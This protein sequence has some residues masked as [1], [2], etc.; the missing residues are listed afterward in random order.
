MK[1]ADESD[2]LQKLGVL[3][4]ALQDDIKKILEIVTSQQDSINKISK[5]SERVENLEY[6]TST[7]KLA[8]R[9]Q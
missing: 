1:N 3:Y 6:D 7:I 8:T 9:Y 5:M 2:E 4:E